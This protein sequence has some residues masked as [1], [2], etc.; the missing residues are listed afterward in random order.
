M[1]ADLRVSIVDAPGRGRPTRSRPSPTSWS[2]RSSRTPRR[3]R[4]LAE[5]L[6][7]AIHDGQKLG[8]PLDYAPLPAA[9]A[10]PRS[11]RARAAL[12]GRGPAAPDRSDERPSRRRPADLS[13]RRRWRW[14]VAR[15]RGR[16][17]ATGSSV[18]L[19]A[20][21][22]RRRRA[23]CSRPWPSQMTR[24]SAL[25]AAS[26]SGSA[27]SSA[28]QLGSGARALRRA[29]VHLRHARLLAAGARSSRCRSRS[30]S[31]SSSPSWRRAGCAGPLG[32]VVELLAAIPSV[33]YGLWGI[34]VLAPLAARHRRAGARRARSGFLPLFRG[35]HHAAS[36]CSPAALDPRHHDPADHRLGEPRGAARRADH[37]ARGRARARRDAL[38]DGRA[39]RCCRT[40]R[41]GSSAR[42]SSASAARSAR[43]W[44]SPWSSATA[45]RSR[46]R[47][48]R[49]A[50]PW[51]ASSPTS[52]PRPPSDL[53]LAALAEIGL[54]L[55]AVTAGAQRRRAAPGLAR[56]RGCPARRRGRP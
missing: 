11:R 41:S 46:P 47:S 4:P 37:A 52:S 35:P 17:S 15:R 18:W 1:P 19:T 33:V 22:R 3:A 26:A 36:A 38:G 27:S 56:R 31:R 16:T 43:P 7:W 28:A 12:T 32:F 42:S 13:R 2:T 21:L 40:A 45:P 5:F 44:R 55:F 34:F 53:Y 54:L 8:P 14:P 23:D 25:S 10:S 20:A 30:G 6:W 50:T 29:A 49:P 48:S 39:R 51:R 24:A 9:G